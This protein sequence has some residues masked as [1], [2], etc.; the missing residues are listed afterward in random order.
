MK[1]IDEF[2]KEVCATKKDYMKAKSLVNRLHGNGNTKNN[3][4]IIYGPG[5]SGK[6]T[7][8][9]ILTRIGANNNV[10]LDFYDDPRM[11][12]FGTIGELI[13][14]T[15]DENRIMNKVDTTFIHTKKILKVDTD[16]IKH[17]KWNI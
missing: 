12:V 15:M 5:S 13:I 4:Y 14:I 10:L 6:T 3:R 16:I 1:S 11:N 17:V 2:L 8:L 7:L 9:R